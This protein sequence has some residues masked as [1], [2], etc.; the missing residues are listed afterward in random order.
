[1]FKPGAVP[2]CLE[3]RNQPVYRNTGVCNPVFINHINI[4]CPR[5][6]SQQELRE[7]KKGSGACVFGCQLIN[8]KMARYI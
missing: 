7:P 8:S 2:F 5:G 6:A 1:M 4:Y 3:I